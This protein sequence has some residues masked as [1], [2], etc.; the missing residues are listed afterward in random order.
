[1]LLHIKTFREY[2]KG[3]SIMKSVTANL[4]GRLLIGGMIVWIVVANFQSMDAAVGYAAFM[5]VPMPNVLTPVAQA[6]LGLGGLLVLTGIRPR[7]G[8]LLIAVFLI[9]VTPLMHQ[10]WA[11]TG[12]DWT[13]EVHFFQSNIML[14]GLCFVLWSTDSSVWKYGFDRQFSEAQSKLFGRIVV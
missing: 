13:I 11:A 6:I 8:L 5:R 12:T 2:K 1:M 9:C 14:L 7:A 10:W 4:V 3:D